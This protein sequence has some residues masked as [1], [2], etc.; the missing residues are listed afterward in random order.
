MTKDLGLDESWRIHLEEE[1][2]KPYMKELTAFLKKERSSK[3]IFPPK[4][5]TFAALNNCPFDQVKVVIF[6]QDPYHGPGQA[7]GLSFSVPPGIKTPP[8]LVNIYKEL[9][10]DLGIPRASHGHL[11]RWAVQ[12][13]LLLNSVLTV[14]SGLAASHQKKGWEQFTDKI[15]EVLNQEKENLVFLLWG[16]Y[17]KKKGAQIDRNKHLVLESGHPSPLS[18]RFFFGK[19]HF[20]RTNKFLEEKKL[21][22][23]DWRVEPGP[24]VRA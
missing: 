23:I 1:F 5:Q 16:N 8:S 7:H 9:Q 20:S 4:G 24:E 10:Y 14:E 6:G 21:R 18:A 3:D 15:V 12:G 11:K 13:V 2:K 19:K 17:A 22:P